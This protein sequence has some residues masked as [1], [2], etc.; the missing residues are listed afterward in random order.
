MIQ[1]KEFDKSF[2]L[3]GKNA[4]ITGGAQG[5]GKAIARIFAE[6]GANIF[7]FDISESGKDTA[8]ELAEN[9]HTKCFFA[10]TDI[11]SQKNLQKSADVAEES[12]GSIDILVNN[13]G[14]VFL[15]NAEE[16]SER[17]W[18]KT[19]AVNQKSVFIASQVIGRKMI[20][21]GGGKIVNIASQAGIVALDKHIAYCASKAAVIS[22]T[23]VLAVEWAKYGINVNAISPTV[24]LTELGKK[25]WAG[26]VGEA[27][28]K[29]IPN[30]RF[31]YPDEIA[32]LA[33]FLAGDASAM[34]NGENILIDGGYTI[35]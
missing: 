33:L 18:D 13:A 22:M 35:K 28:K 24:V 4:V 15:D 1:Y 32:S 9:F 6:K 8:S 7:L 10:K 17:D 29:M 19:I 20:K 26:D 16:L 25:A 2:N 11:T 5:I 12:L 30:G 3:N 31:A 23:K 27:M 21:R 14:V 34:I